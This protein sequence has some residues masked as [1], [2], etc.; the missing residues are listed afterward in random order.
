M[1]LGV[2]IF[3][4]DKTMPITDLARA[5]EERGFESLWFAEHT[6]IPVSRATPYP[7]GGELPDEYRRTF[8]P[9]V[10]IAAAAAVT[11]RIKLGTAICLVAQH[12]T[13]DLAKSVASVDRLSNGRFLFGVGYGWNVEEMEDHGVDHK[14]RRAIVRE[15]LLAAR[16][17]WTKD[18]ASFEGEHLRLSA[19]WMWPKPVQQPHPP[20]LF[21][22]APGPKLFRE[23]VELGD[24][25]IPIGGRGLREALPE[26]RRLMEEAGREPDAL[27]VTTV[28]VTPDSV[29]KLRHYESLGV[30]RVVFFL[31]SSG[32]D[33]VLPLLDRY[34][35]DFLAV[36]R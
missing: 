19:S 10:T 6:H 18:E 15:K 29:D 5:V 13:I 4:T 23:I 9:F 8:D 28:G 1:E 25:W 24:G 31:P 3:L 30:S 32:A 7:M 2:T 14:R 34:T 26:L 27:D 35:N 21:G 33:A 11:E 17:L 20:I 16:E 22:G 12:D 36:L